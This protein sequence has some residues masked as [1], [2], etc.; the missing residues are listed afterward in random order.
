MCDAKLLVQGNVFN[1][2]RLVLAAAS[3]RFATAFKT[4]DDKPLEVEGSPEAVSVLL[5]YLYVGKVSVSEAMLEQMRALAEQLKLSSLLSDV[6]AIIATKV[7]TPPPLPFPSH[8]PRPSHCTL[9]HITPASSRA[10]DPHGTRLSVGADG[11][12]EARAR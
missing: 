12:G 7:R 2:H 8:T 9:G 4:L 1:V 5:E 6:R 10:S 11:R 3:T